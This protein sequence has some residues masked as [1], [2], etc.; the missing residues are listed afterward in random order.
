[1]FNLLNKVIYHKINSIVI[2]SFVRLNSGTLYTI[3]YENP[4][5]IDLII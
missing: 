2:S 3:L 1:V 5:W 4:D